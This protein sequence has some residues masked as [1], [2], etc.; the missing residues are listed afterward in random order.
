MMR[1]LWT[2]VAALALGAGALA[3]QNAEDV[4]LEQRSMSG[5]RLGLTFVAGARARD[6]LR[7]RDLAPLLSQFGWHFEQI[8]RP[9]GG[10]PMF[11]IQEVLLLGAV[12]Q[13][14]VVPAGTVA[15]GIRFPSGIEFGMGPNATPVGTALAMG[16]GWRMQ[17][18]GVAVPFNLAL[19]YSPGSVRISVLTGYAMRT[20]RRTQTP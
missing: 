2:A 7:D 18:G 16:V 20:M 13:Q 11:V 15:F 9:Q 3:A 17:Y 4:V 1:A 19:V 14:T 6:V 10:G 12:E 5:P 8:T